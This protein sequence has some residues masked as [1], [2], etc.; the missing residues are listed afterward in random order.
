MADKRSDRKPNEQQ[1]VPVVTADPALVAAMADA[2]AQR[3]ARAAEVADEAKA[4]TED[5][6]VAGGRYLVGD[7]LVDAEG[8]P[9]KGKK[10]RED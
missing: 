10:D 7:Q 2:E 8:K 6:E 5:H 9:I 1:D 3:Q 4:I